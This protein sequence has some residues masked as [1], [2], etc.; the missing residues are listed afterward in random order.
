[1]LLIAAYSTDVP[2]V[3][4]VEHSSAASVGQVKPEDASIVCVVVDDA[5]CDDE[6][7]VEDF[8]FLAAAEASPMGHIESHCCGGP[9][10]VFFSLA[11]AVV[12]VLPGRC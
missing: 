12:G 1:M 5:A 3:L 11:A 2:A 6:V 8:Y 7:V 4:V 9:S 10:M